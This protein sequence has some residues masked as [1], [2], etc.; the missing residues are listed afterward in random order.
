MMTLSPRWTLF[1]PGLVLVLVGTG[2]LVALGLGPVRLGEVT[3]GVHSMVAA[4]LLVI[5]GYQA[6]TTAIAAR[7][8]AVEEEIGPPG[9]WLRQAFRVFTLERGLLAGVALVLAGVGT[10]GAL[11]WRWAAAGFGQLEPEQSLRPMILGATL[12]ALG[13]QTLLMSFV[14][15]MLGIKRRRGP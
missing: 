1:A 4:S 3:L 9:P 5:V 2:A 7:I 11:A 8:Y 10:I 13:I 12:V 14:Y 6:M 15:S